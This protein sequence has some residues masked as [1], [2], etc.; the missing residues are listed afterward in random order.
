M[1]LIWRSC[2]RKPE[3]RP[4]SY[5]PVA[6]AADDGAAAY[7]PPPGG[8]AEVDGTS[9]LAYSVVSPSQGP[10][11]HDDDA[12]TIVYS[13]HPGRDN[14]SKM[15]SVVSTPSP[16]PPPPVSPVQTPSPPPPT[17]LQHVSAYPNM[18]ELQGHGRN[19]SEL[20][21]QAWQQ[22]QQQQAYQ[23]VQAQAGHAPPVH[24]ATGYQT[25]RPGYQE[26]E[27]AR[28]PEVAGDTHITQELH[29]AHITPELHGAPY[30]S[31]VYEMSTTPRPR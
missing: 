22:H 17:H 13:V 24:T 19:V 20:Q 31:R 29:G 6:H 27:G 21:A 30:N 23:M 2:L 11:R 26:M 1:F 3:Q 4:V 10:G 12:S 16:A 7:P 14:V 25:A 9:T 5:A 15:T 18:S 8:R 28:P